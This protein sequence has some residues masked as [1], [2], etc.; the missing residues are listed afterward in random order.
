[1]NYES[2]KTND[3]SRLN[4]CFLQ[5]RLY[6]LTVSM[7][8]VCC[9][10]LSTESFVGCSFTRKL[11]YWVSLWESTSMETR[12]TCAA[13]LWFPKVYNF[14]FSYP[15]T[16]L[17]NTQQWFVSENRISAETCLPI[18]FLGTAYMSQLCVGTYYIH[19]PN[20]YWAWRCWKH[21]RSIFTWIQ[22]YG[23][24]LKYVA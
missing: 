14:H 19:N 3:D 16:R 21:D 15:W 12:V 1:M 10:F 4:R 23:S 24:M 17:V 18:R 6:S 7:E 2:R 20:L 22:V 5:D 11:L 13:T 8:N 9:L